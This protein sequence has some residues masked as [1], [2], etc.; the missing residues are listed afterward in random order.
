MSTSFADCLI[1]CSLPPTLFLELLAVPK[2]ILCVIVLGRF[3]IFNIS[4]PQKMFLE[5]LV[6]PKLSILVIVLG[7][8]PISV[9]SAPEIV[10][11]GAGL[12]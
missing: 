2:L 8:L 1:A 11:R 10:L 3:P 7:R 5:E 6:L 4:A 12:D 9:F